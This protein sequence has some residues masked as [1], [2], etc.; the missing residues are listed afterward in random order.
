MARLQVLLAAVCF[1]TTGTAQALGPSIEPVLVGSARIAIG[2]LLLTLVAVLVA[3]TD[4]SSRPAR[5]RDRRGTLLIAGGCVAAYQVTFF[6]A[7]AETGVAVGTVVAIGSAPAWTGAFDRLTGGD[8]LGLRWLGATVLAC[9]GVALLILG[10]GDAQVEPG[11]VGLA[12]LAGAGYAAYAVA[13]KRLLDAGHAPETVMAGVFGTGA[14]LVA[15]LLV[16]VPADELAT[17]AGAA[18]VVY[19][20]AVPTALAYVLF[21]RGLRQI[22]A[23]ETA[24]L[25]LAEPLTA[26]LLGV[27][28]LDER[29]GAVAVMGAGLVLAGLLLL[30]LR[31][32]PLRA[33]P[34]IVGPA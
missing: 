18:L 10:G 28:V 4:R 23:A 31:R 15:P 29:P 20:G 9:I 30:A 6:A 33:L 3:R 13:S 24:T 14:L 1:G 7:V 11:G 32:T 25:T 5:L 34:S 8:V 27:V 16:L 2:A 19:L 12:A 17:P 21:A 26:A 22:P